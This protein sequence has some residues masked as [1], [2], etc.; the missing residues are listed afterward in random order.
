MHHVIADRDI[1]AL[2][3]YPKGTKCFLRAKGTAEQWNPWTGEVTSL[4]NF[5]NPVSGG[6]ELELS[7]SYIQHIGK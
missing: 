6:T 4:A 1:Y 7:F 5:A 3:N 2:Y